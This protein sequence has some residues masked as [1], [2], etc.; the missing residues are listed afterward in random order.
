MH[1]IISQHTEDC[2]KRGGQAVEDK[3]SAWEKYTLHGVV[4]CGGVDLR[5]LWVRAGGG[6]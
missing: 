3:Q 4:K 5:K 6:L 2:M 1:A